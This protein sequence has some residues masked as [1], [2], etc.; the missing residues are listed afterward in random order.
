MTAES[1]Y[2]IRYQMEHKLRKELQRE[3]S[4]YQELQK[5]RPLY[6][7]VKAE[8]DKLKQEVVKLQRDNATVQKQ[9]DTIGQQV[10][11]IASLRLE[12]MDLE[13]HNHVMKESIDKA[14]TELAELCKSA[15]ELP[16]AEIEHKLDDV[17]D[18]LSGAYTNYEE[19]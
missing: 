5:L 19:E 14:T 7:E 12:Q 8:R 3:V 2:K 10:M 18:Y 4:A 11:E 15:K 17:V 13:S 16:A 6:A 9:A 1:D